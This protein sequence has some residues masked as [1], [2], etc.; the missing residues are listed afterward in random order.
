MGPGDNVF[1]TVGVWNM[2]S[3]AYQDNGDWGEMDELRRAYLDEILVQQ[4]VACLA[5]G[6]GSLSAKGW[7]YRKVP[8]YSRLCELV[9]SLDV[10]TQ[11]CRN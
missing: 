5:Y 2:G 11:Y 1:L 8:W 4:I 9:S 6:E 3:Q 10:V 7:G